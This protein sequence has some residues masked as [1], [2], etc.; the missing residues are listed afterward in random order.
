VAGLIVLT[1]AG[2]I[3]FTVAGLIV[4]TVRSAVM[5]AGPQAYGEYRPR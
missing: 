2:L 3:V 4:L 1:V 5:P